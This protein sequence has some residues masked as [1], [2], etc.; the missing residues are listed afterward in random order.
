M[1]NRCPPPVV[2]AL[3]VLSAL[4]AGGCGREDRGATS[5]GHPLLGTK[6]A[7]V[8]APGDGALTDADE[9]QRR[10]IDA[11]RAAPIPGDTPAVVVDNPRNGSVYPPDIVAPT[12]TWTDATE[13]ADTWLL[14]VAFEGDD[15]ARLAVLVPG[16]PQPPAAIDEACV[17]ETNELPE[18]PGAFD[19]S[20]TPPR[21]LW[22]TM[23]KRSKERWATLTITGRSS[24]APGRALSVARLR[25][26][27]SE[28][29]VG[30][31][32]FY[33]D[34][35]LAPSNTE[36]GVIKPL[37]DDAVALIKWRLRDIGRPESRVVLE[38]MVTC[39]NCHSFSLDGTTFG[40]DVDGP[41]GDKGTYA[42]LP[43]RKQMVIDYENIITWNDYPKKPKG[44]NTRGFLSRVSPTGR[45]AV[46]TLNEA[47]Y[48]ANF[49]DYRFLQ[50]FYPT[51][52][53]L[54]YYDRK[55]HVMDALPGADD[56]A[57]VHCDAVWSPDGSEIVFARAPA[58]DAYQPG[59]PLAKYANDPNE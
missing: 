15:A 3:G 23:K 16:D 36:K 49:L 37:A 53:I 30:A 39:A 27:T 24:A 54:A 48:V 43:V 29:P 13:G 18:A 45:Y 5:G 55:T 50:V 26:R 12:F 7:V 32:I 11:A 46:T 2:I 10:F 42:F 57:Y 17:A 4:L 19:R 44:H 25:F 56:P 40:M 59:V 51:R 38:R 9:A 34:V 20:F 58:K 14:D 35:P 52:G 47:V 1:T 31:P 6:S 28:D 8:L 22:E 33:R 41:Q 21:E